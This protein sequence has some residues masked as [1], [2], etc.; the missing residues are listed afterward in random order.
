MDH[1]IYYRCCV[2][3]FLLL[4]QCCWSSESSE[5]P[6]FMLTN[7]AFLRRLGS[8]FGGSERIATGSSWRYS[9]PGTVDPE[10]DRCAENLF[11]GAFACCWRWRSHNY[12][13]SLYRWVCNSD[14]KVTACSQ[15]PDP[16]STPTSQFREPYT[17][18]REVSIDVKYT[19]EMFLLIEGSNILEQQVGSAQQFSFAIV[20]GVAHG[21]SITEPAVQLEAPPTLHFDA[22]TEISTLNATIKF[23][24]DES[25]HKLYDAEMFESAGLNGTTNSTLNETMSNVDHAIMGS[26]DDLMRTDSFKAHLTSAFQKLGDQYVSLEIATLQVHRLETKTY[27]SAVVDF[28]RFS[29]GIS[30]TLLATLLSITCVQVQS[31][32]C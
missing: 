10:G 4:Q 2:L 28:A 8:A 12:N 15:A 3:F 26:S 32:T 9:R 13:Y 7:D 6:A 18:V 19:L 14:P 24:E 21:L 25:L 23:A 22:S 1:A 27:G 16:G 20:S 5:V 17:C 31:L 29:A 11:V 30:S